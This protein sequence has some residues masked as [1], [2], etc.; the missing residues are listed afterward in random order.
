MR[1]PKVF[2]AKQVPSE[3]EA[4]IAEY[5]EYT[6]WDREDE[7]PREQLLEA[8]SD[9][10]GL[11]ISGGSIDQE[12][13]DRAPKLRIVSNVSVGYNNL[14]LSAMKER[15]VLGTHTP[16]VLD[17]TVADTVFGLIL[18]SA[19]RIPELDAYVKAGR[20][21]KGS[22][23]AIF[24]IDVHHAKL[25]IIGL[26]R[27]GEAIARRAKFGF[28]MD[29]V[30]YNRSR[31]EAAE[32]SLGVSYRSLQDLLRESDFVVL[33]T[34]LTADT[35]RLIGREELALMKKSAIFINA[36]RGQTVDEAALIEA[37]EQGIIRGAG[38]DVFEQEPVAP[39]NPLLRMPNVVTLPHIGSATHKTRFDMAMLAA[40]NLVK[41]VLGEVP[42]NVVPEL[43]K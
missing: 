26:G 13:L 37:L 10:D 9:V 12:L 22:D 1:R 11:L 31:K 24:G 43:R 16:G 34:P 33:M 18:A 21:Q 27:I 41:G 23:E 3:V 25:G 39:D 36:S 19:R 30:Y 5:C 35:A 40:E 6:K 17:E 4:Y 29:V 20:W 42:P 8:L 28:S 38:L 2:L 32:Q 7:M 15:A 14:N